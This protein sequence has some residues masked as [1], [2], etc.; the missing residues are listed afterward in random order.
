[1]PR[2]SFAIYRGA[3]SPS[4]R[5]SLL[6]QLRVTFEDLRWELLGFEPPAS[7]TAEESQARCE[8]STYPERRC[9]KFYF[10][11]F[12][13]GNQTRFFLIDTSALGGHEK[14]LCRCLIVMNFE[15][16]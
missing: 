14:A 3:F 8:N 10:V 11:A 16:Q 4:A 5:V 6:G 12:F 13:K 15:C 9:W 7:L 1:M 2:P